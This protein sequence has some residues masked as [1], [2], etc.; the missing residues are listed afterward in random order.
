MR[1]DG[2]RLILLCFC[3]GV[4]TLAHAAPLRV[5]EI[6]LEA[7]GSGEQLEIH[8]DGALAPQKTFTL[9]NPPR[10]VVD[11]PHVEGKGVRLPARYAGPLVHAVRFGQFNPTT[12]RVVI[13]TKQP[14]RLAEV[15]EGKTLLLTLSPAND[16]R[17]PEPS[18]DTPL[19][20][21]KDEEPEAKPEP[22]SGAAAKPAEAATAL[23]NKPLV[24]IDAGHGGQDP[25]ALGLHGTHEKD[26]T[27]NYAL[28][29]R[30][31][32]LRTGR[33]RV[34]LTRDDDHFVMLRERV[35]IARRAKA[36][37]FISFHADSNPNPEARGLT[38]YTVSENASDEESAALAERENK[39]DIVPGLNLNTTDQDVANI[40]IDLTQRETMNKS[41]RF[42]DAI[43]ANMPNSIGK[44]QKAHRF[45][46]FRVL[47]GP[48]I[49]SVLIELGFVTNAE[50]E[51]MLLTPSYREKVV[52]SVVKGIE[53]YRAEAKKR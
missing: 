33:Y 6:R 21:E 41:A 24:A 22:R 14:A 2:L 48:D 45:A 11:L 13:E 4:A 37:M 28:H 47:K 27:L 39:A 51:R 10:V 49:P 34:I 43:V 12:S 3:A 35:E 16:A 38:V 23:E 17:A 7:S 20:K 30:E 15:K 50:D 25:G 42:A 18:S 1:R 52:A 40:L 9:A 36:D 29:L 53:R 32:L 46:G 31:A 8:A 5:S 44:V 26:V 19:P